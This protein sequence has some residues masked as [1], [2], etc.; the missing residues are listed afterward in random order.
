MFEGS[1]DKL[2]L[3]AA[4]FNRCHFLGFV[5]YSAECQDFSTNEIGSVNKTPKVSGSSETTQVCLNP[6]QI[7]EAVRRS[8]IE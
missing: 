2:K 3:I 6:T 8:R 4:T 5:L 7:S 1:F